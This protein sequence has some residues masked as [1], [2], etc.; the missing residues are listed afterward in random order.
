M[1]GKDVFLK[2]MI[3]KESIVLIKE[4]KRDSFVENYIYFIYLKSFWKKICILKI[5][6]DENLII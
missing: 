4:L 6:C 2:G 1:L 5:S 3:F